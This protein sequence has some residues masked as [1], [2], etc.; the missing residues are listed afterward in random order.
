MYIKEREG[1]PWAEKHILLI[2]Q[3]LFLL[4]FKFLSR[5][6]VPYTCAANGDAVKKTTMFKLQEL[7]C[8]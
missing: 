4:T 6:V 7:I 1:E 2:S 8:R 5:K 3:F